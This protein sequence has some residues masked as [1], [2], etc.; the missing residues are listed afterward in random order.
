MDT[1]LT[2]NIFFFYFCFFLFRLDYPKGE[3][4]RVE[5]FKSEAAE[6]SKLLKIPELQSSQ[7]ETKVKLRLVF[8]QTVYNISSRRSVKMKVQ[9]NGK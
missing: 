7:Q 2:H 5:H 8:P 4:R 9:L 1:V 6:T 3:L